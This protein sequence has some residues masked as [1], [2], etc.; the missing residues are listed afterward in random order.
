MALLR[1]VDHAVVEC[2]LFN[3]TVEYINMF[4]L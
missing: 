2:S 4:P 1:A 3:R